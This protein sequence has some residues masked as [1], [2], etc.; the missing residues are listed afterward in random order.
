MYQ[1]QVQLPTVPA[2]DDE[3]EE[4]LDPLE[5]D[6]DYE[7]MWKTKLCRKWLETGV[8]P[9][10]DHCEFA[11]GTCELRPVSHP[12]YKKEVCRMVLNGGFCHYAGCH[13]RQALTIREKHLIF[14]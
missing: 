1:P 9:N 7:G 2:V 14:N 4:E 3:E 6:G 11:H 12:G 10:G 8:C 13:F 5:L